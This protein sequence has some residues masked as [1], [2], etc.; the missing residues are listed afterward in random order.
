MFYRNVFT[1]LCFAFFAVG[2]GSNSPTAFLMTLFF[3]AL[4][5]TA[6]KKGWRDPHFMTRPVGDEE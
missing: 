2:V 4:S 6:V 3:G 1:A 5:R